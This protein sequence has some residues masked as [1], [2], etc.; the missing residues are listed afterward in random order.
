MQLVA[1]IFII[2]HKTNWRENI[3]NTKRIG[4]KIYITQNELTGK[5]T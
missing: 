4:G 2:T 1:Y 3:H 5:Y